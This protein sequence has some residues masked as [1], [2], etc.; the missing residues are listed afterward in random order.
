MRAMILAAGYGTRL[1]PLTIDR[2]KPA[3]PFMGR[4][5]VGYVAEYLARF[6]FGEIAVNLHHRGES[7]RAALGDGGRFGVRFH[8]V[9]EP[10]ILG[11]GGALDNARDFLEAETFVVVNGKIA[12]DI[13]LDAALETHRRARALATLVL[14]ENAARERYSMVEVRDGLVTGF[15]GSPTSDNVSGAGSAAQTEMS[16]AGNEFR[17]GAGTDFREGRGEK[18]G[19]RRVESRV[20]VE[21]V[22]K[23]GGKAGPTPLMFTG[24]QILDPRIFDYIPRGVFSH[25]V[26]D[27][28]I[29]AIARGERVAAH[30]AEGDWY[31]LSTVRRYLETSV[32]LLKRE[33][34]ALELGDGSRVA[35][36]ADV[37]E[38]VLWENARVAGGAR[39]RRSVLGAGVVVEQGEV[40]ENVAVV[41][42]ELVRGVECP[43]K[44]LRGEVRGSN[45]VAPI[46]E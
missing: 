32:A 6:G 10:T 34:R 15:G 35:D 37:G 29:P 20:G 12:T 13:N 2:A 14:R 45:F 46:P 26:T 27:T 21:A 25:T 19:G 28:F 22:T 30:V 23:V 41:R 18:V 38:S 43:P 1:W 36:S 31:E 16:N 8:Y 7:V 24:I 44:G 5:L 42:A 4:P 17:E 33:G 9:E 11:T 39:V 40:F 3:I